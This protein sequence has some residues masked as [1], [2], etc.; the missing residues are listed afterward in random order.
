[1]GRIFF[2]NLIEIEQVEIYIDRVAETHE[3]KE[4]LW[5]LVDEYIN[6][7]IVSSILSQLDENSQ[8]E[9]LSMFLTKPYDSG[10]NDYLDSKLDDPLE[11]LIGL[12]TE[13]IVKELEELFEIQLPEKKKLGKN[14]GKKKKK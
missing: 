7:K 6:R 13:N 2:D 11:Y 4:D 5:E 10:I 12:S 3:E 14:A 9:F 8:E 1:M